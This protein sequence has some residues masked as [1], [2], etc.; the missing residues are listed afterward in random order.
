MF[1]AD[2]VYG[3]TVTAGLRGVVPPFLELP[4]SQ[5]IKGNATC[6]LEMTGL[7]LL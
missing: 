3:L 5:E 2:R 1:V 4:T 6:G 7:V